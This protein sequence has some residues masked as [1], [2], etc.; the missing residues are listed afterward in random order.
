M[1]GG[2]VAARSGG[3]APPPLAP[4]RGT[5]NIKVVVVVVDDD[6]G[7]DRGGRPAED[8]INSYSAAASI[9]EMFNLNS[10]RD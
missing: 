7:G 2:G 3:L 1:S 5:V 10:Y 4:V 9:A 6:G 8:L